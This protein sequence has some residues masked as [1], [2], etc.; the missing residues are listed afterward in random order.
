MRRQGFEWRAVSRPLW[1]NHRRQVR[2]LVCAVVLEQELP[3]RR[4]LE[5]DGAARVV[6]GIPP[7]LRC[8]Q[9]QW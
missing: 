8:K 1:C 5:W 3:S 2:K 4:C 9:V 7:A 6:G